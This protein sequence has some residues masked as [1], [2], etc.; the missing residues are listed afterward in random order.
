MRVLTRRNRVVIIITVT[1]GHLVTTTA[2]GIIT[3]MKMKIMLSSD[4]SLENL[5]E[6]K[7]VNVRNS[8]AFVLTPQIDFALASFTPFS[9]VHVVR[10]FAAKIESD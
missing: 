1:I 4:L 10:V 8:V 9:T 6:T 7:Q 2:K 5:V 3:T